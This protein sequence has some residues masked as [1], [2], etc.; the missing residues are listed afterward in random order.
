MQEIQHQMTLNDK[1]Q[2]AW[3]LHKVCYIV[4]TSLSDILEHLW[5]VF[6]TFID[7]M[8]E[9]ANLLSVSLTPV[10]SNIA[11]NISKNI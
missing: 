11:D 10:F 3:K 9:L 5:K 7:A 6:N 1:W 4:V 2:I 8:Q